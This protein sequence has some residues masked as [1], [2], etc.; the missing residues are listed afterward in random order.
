MKSMWNSLIQPHIDYCSQLVMPLQS[1]NLTK[2]EK[3]LKDYTSRIPELREYTY[4]ERLY[5]LKM[6]S[7]QRR[8]ER[9][10][11]IYTWKILENL[12]PNCGIY[13]EGP[14][15]RGGRKC[16]VAPINLKCGRKVQKLRE[17]NF[18]EEW[19]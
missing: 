8:M 10:R 18:S 14:L 7:M 9:Y 12:V 16:K 19:S 5:K 1:S 13:R 3:L 11:I 2:I 17:H 15:E 4:W 6:N